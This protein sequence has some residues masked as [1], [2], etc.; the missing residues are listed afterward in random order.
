M[1]VENMNREGFRH[2]AGDFT[3]R[4]DLARE[5]QVIAEEQ[6]AKNRKAEQLSNNQVAV[7]ESPTPEKA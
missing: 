5:L 6:A 7:E 4:N 2:P 3:S 1:S